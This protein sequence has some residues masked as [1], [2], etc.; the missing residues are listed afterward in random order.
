MATS[1]ATL[2]SVAA[3]PHIS[4][5]VYVPIDS[6][7]NDKFGISRGLRNA[8]LVGDYTK[9]TAIRP[10][11]QSLFNAFS[12]MHPTIAAISIPP[13]KVGE[14]DKFDNSGALNTEQRWLQ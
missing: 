10:I 13:L 12:V 9:I 11:Y 6:V 4:F 14:S 3:V 7:E 1:H 5:V 2:S 8:S